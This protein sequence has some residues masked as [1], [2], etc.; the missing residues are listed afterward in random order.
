MSAAEVL[1]DTLA[2]GAT[3]ERRAA[4]R[5]LLRHPLLTASKPAPEA[6]R[7]VRKHAGALRQWFAEETG[8]SLV[9]DPDVARLR[10]TPVNGGDA[11]RPARARRGG[12]PLTRRRYILLCLALAALE[13][14]DPQV[15]LGLLAE[16]VLAAAADEALVAA[17]VRF[18]L[19]HRDERADLVAAIRVLL[20]LGVLSRVAGDEQSYVD[21]RGDAL[22]DLDRRVLAGLLAS[23]RGPSMV[24]APSTPERLAA[25]VDD[26]G[27]DAG[28]GGPAAVRRRLARRLL[29]DPVVYLDD[30]DDVEREYL[31][32]QRTHLLARLADGTGLEPEARA[33]GLALLDPTGETTDLSMPEEGTDGHATLLLA[34]YLA[35]PERHDRWVPLDELE[36]H[37]AALVEEHGPHWRKAVRE[38]GG[39][40]DL[41]ATA[42]G[43]L[44][45][46]DLVEREG[47]AVRGRPA[48][49][50]YAADPATVAG[51][52]QGTL[53]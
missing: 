24:S 9:V 28:L 35:D 36:T 4:A 39:A 33:E 40:R 18:T 20:E 14:A 51:S 53:T 42:V 2:R 19:E 23:P 6:F 3:E 15:T 45:A 21:E 32:T 46:L 1:A 44:L 8:W 11:T 38:P 13:R 22:Y 25:L 7:A 12:P 29:D 27:L 49:A 48:L 17:G 30:L 52:G 47:E 26:P 37:T 10:K 43:R 31:R 34:T 41:A 50:R 16:Q 5:A